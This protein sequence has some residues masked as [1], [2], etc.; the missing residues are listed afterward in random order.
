MI[1]F[2]L[3]SHSCPPQTPRHTKDPSFSAHRI[4][5]TYCLTA[6]K[7]TPQPRVSQAPPK[8]KAKCNPYRLFAIR[9][10]RCPTSVVPSVLIRH[11]GQLPNSHTYLSIHTTNSTRKIH[12][13]PLSLLR[14]TSALTYIHAISPSLSLAQLL[15]VRLLYN[16]TERAAGL[17]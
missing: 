11:P 15:L 14:P 16:R 6:K 3:L 4:P 9:P 5:D 10:R 17:D 12:F 2:L 7:W 13:Y 1:L 8:Q